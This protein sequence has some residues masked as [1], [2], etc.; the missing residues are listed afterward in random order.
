MRVRGGG[1]HVLRR[2][3]ASRARRASH[4]SAIRLL[5][6]GA[7]PTGHTVSP[8]V[9]RKPPQPT[10]PFPRPPVLTPTRHASATHLTA[11]VRSGLP[12][13]RR[14]RGVRLPYA[15]PPCPAVCLAVRL[16]V[17]HGVPPS[18]CAREPSAG[19]TVRRPPVADNWVSTSATYVVP[20]CEGQSETW[21]EEAAARGRKG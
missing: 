19:P 7:S 1:S 4:G 17:R 11:T 10:G 14:R 13:A 5:P 20:R 2:G 18:L 15:R 3:S 12:P 6:C 21:S 8:R 16:A 9:V